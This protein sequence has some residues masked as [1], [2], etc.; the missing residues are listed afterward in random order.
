MTYKT[1]DSEYGRRIFN[2]QFNGKKNIFTDEIIGYFATDS[3]KI[4]ELSHGKFI[5]TDMFG[6]TVIDTKAATHNHDLSKCLSSK[7]LAMEY[8][9]TL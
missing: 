9:G 7:E 2:Q 5:S 8:I 6:V 3:G 1:V 4:V